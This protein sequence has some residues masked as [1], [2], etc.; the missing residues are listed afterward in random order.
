MS[1]GNA[2]SGVALKSTR[3][4][5][6]APAPSTA[7]VFSAIKLNRRTSVPLTQ[8]SGLSSCIFFARGVSG[9]RGGN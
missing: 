1:R 6:V 5:I 9:W 4:P 2:F 3:C 8:Q 7:V